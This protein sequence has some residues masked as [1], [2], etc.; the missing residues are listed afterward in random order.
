MVSMDCDIVSFVVTLLIYISV[1]IACDNVPLIVTP[2]VCKRLSIAYDNEY[3][4]L[5]SVFI[6]YDNLSCVVTFNVVYF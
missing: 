5:T 6:A 2:L 4:V 1:P 3:P